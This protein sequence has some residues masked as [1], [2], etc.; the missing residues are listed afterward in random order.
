MSR[1]LGNVGEDVACEYLV[2]LGYRIL[3]RNFYSRYGEID[4]VAQDSEALVFFEVKS[5][6][7][8]SYIHPL[9]SV[10]VAKQ[11][12]MI[13][14]IQCYLV[15]NNMETLFKRIDLLVVQAPQSV[16]HY[17]NIITL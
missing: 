11:Q 13:K 7:M 8:G 5:Y 6:S 1:H 16:D 4:I 3:S 12:R 2:S 9:E 10:T 15:K 14:T 17:R